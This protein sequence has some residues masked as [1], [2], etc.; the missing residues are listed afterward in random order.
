MRTKHLAFSILFVFIAL[1]IGGCRKEIPLNIDSKDRKIVV[2]GILIPDS[3][4]CINLS[5]SSSIAEKDLNEYRY[6]E[7]ANVGLFENGI[8]VTHLT[9]TNNGY[10]K[11]D[12]DFRPKAGNFY[13]L[14]V[15]HEGKTASSE[16]FLPKK[17]LN[18]SIDVKKIRSYSFEKDD[19]VVYSL[20]IYISINDNGN[21]KN[22]YCISFGY[23]VFQ[24]RYYGKDLPISQIII[25][26]SKF[27]LY[28]PAVEFSNFNY[29]NDDEKLEKGIY[30]QFVYFSNELFRGQKHN[31]RLETNLSPFYVKEGKDSA[32][33]Y[34]YISMIDENY[35]RYRKYIAE[36]DNDD[37]FFSEKVQIV[38]N[39][40]N[41][42]GLFSGIT[43]IV[44][45]FSIAINEFPSMLIQQ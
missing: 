2:N 23:P 5:K 16:F 7:N 38:N 21:N 33:F 9:S 41:G 29:L 11:S 40:N 45:S 3:A 35:F 39:I 18:H 10:Y 36:Y 28:S 22:Y 37:D 24:N 13:K 27:T 4:V 8:L 19:S 30:G 32:T 31:L 43:C 44:D 20:K 12:N 42:I 6:I 25:Y 1:I 14:I 17:E 26:N 34:L 15:E